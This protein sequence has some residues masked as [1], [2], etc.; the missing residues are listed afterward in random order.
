MGGVIYLLAL[1]LLTYTALL[2][3]SGTILL[4]VFCGVVFAALAYLYVFVQMFLIR[5]ELSLPAGVAAPGEKK[6]LVFTCHNRG[7]FPVIKIKGY[8]SCTNSYSG[9]RRRLV[10]TG[11][12]GGKQMELYRTVRGNHCGVVTYRLRKLRVYDLTGIF[13]LARRCDRCVELTV[14]PPAYAAAVHVTERCRSFAGDSEIYDQGRPG[15]DA[16]EVYSVRP[17][18]DGDRIQ[19]IHWKLSVRSDSLIVRENSR[20]LGAPVVLYVEPAAPGG[21]K[22]AVT[23][24]AQFAV[25]AS[26][27]L[28]LA[29][30]G[31][32][33]YIAWYDRVSGDVARMRADC[34]EDMYR[35]MMAMYEGV[36]RCR[37][38]SGRRRREDVEAAGLRE[39]YLDKYRGEQVVTEISVSR[40]AVLAVNGVCCRRMD[41]RKLEEELS[42][43]ELIV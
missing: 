3:E 23:A 34:G 33:H 37:Y 7:I 4:C 24:D 1:M 29:E 5:T 2:Y 30:Q 9:E 11:S 20:P 31:C 27:S 14:M 12:P 25:A 36:V 17:F 22:K 41:L 39:R 28:A 8:V 10:I 38:L 43:V 16:S 18:K 15:A 21:R 19:N 13:S 32:A 42:G 40:E 26:V 6:K 35:A